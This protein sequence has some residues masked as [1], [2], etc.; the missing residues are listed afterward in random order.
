MGGSRK[1]EEQTGR[2]RDSVGF[3]ALRQRLRWCLWDAGVEPGSCLPDCSAL[4]AVACSWGVLKFLGEEAWQAGASLRP[5]EHGWYQDQHGLSPLK[6]LG[7][8]SVNVY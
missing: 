7:G 2:H 5:G 3:P 1:V 8:L 6:A 4:L